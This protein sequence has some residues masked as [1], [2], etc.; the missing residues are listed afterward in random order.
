M[1]LLA[2][3]KVHTNCL[4]KCLKENCLSSSDFKFEFD[5]GFGSDFEL[6]MQF[7]KRIILI[8]EMIIML[9]LHPFQ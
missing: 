2:G 3:L 6:Q 9:K 8:L 7:C 1:K 4:M 5:C